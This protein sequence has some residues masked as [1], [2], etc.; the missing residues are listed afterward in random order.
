MSAIGRAIAPRD[1]LLQMGSQSCPNVY[2]L[3]FFERR[4][5]L[6]SQ[7][8]RALNLLYS[9]RTESLL[10]PSSSV[11]VVGG[12]ASGLTVA[13]GAAAL[14][15]KVSLFERRDRLI[16]LFENSDRPLHPH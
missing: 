12:G 9:L 10:S 16:P 11:A 1:L 7:Q 3:G 13:A 14:G 8:V 15:C 4:V 5:T 2:L 6:L